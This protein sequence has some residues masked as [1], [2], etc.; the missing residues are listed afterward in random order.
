MYLL[1]YVQ[2]FSLIFTIFFLPL[3]PGTQLREK[4]RDILEVFLS[5]FTADSEYGIYISNILYTYI[6][7]FYKYV[8]FI[9]ILYILIFSVHIS[10]LFINPY[11]YS[12]MST[13]RIMSLKFENITVINRLSLLQY[14][15]KILN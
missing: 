8:L 3:I 13:F 4:P 6:Y 1:T 12:C 10:S 14:Y 9:I 2:G 11:Y 5:T 15:L 7:I